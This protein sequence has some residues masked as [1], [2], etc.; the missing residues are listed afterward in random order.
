V[1]APRALWKGFLK[2]GSITCA[3]KLV[4]AVS[5]AGKIHFRTLNRKTRQPV[6]A[7]YVDEETGDPVE[8]D[9]QVK[10]YELEKGEFLLVEPEE[11]TRLKK[12]GEHR[13][14]IDGFVD[15]A[16]VSSIYREKPYYLLPGDRLANEPYALIKAALEGEGV[17]AIGRVVMQ[18]RERSVLVEPMDGGLVM[19]LLRQANEVVAD[20]QIFDGIPKGE[21][22]PELGEIAAMLIDRKAASFD[23]ADFEDRYENA[24]AAMLEAR[25]KGKKP[26]KPAPKPREKV[27]NLASLLKK[28][29]EQ[30]GKRAKP[31][32][33][34]AA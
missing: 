25:K 7:I 5:E 4:G 33:R 18:Q 6:K 17:D 11:I 13:L 14:D 32:N 19:T 31:A 22:D 16:S 10:G 1:A 15:R 2:L 3:V 28:S 8:R 34:K 9:E 24:L 30:E 23:P 27:A 26:P 29:L 20:K 21:V 12:A